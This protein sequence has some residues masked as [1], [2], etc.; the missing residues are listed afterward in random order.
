MYVQKCWLL[1]EKIKDERVFTKK[2]STIYKKPVCT[3]RSSMSN[4]KKYIFTVPRPP[5]PPPTLAFPG[6]VDNTG[7]SPASKNPSVPSGTCPAGDR[8]VL[9]TRP[10][11]EAN[12]I[13]PGSQ[14]NCS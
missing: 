10:S 13:R 12:A 4:Q 8:P 11:L 6:C 1:T 5:P 3:K 9:Q 7:Q 2:V 14:L